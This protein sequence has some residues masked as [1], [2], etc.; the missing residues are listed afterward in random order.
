MTQKLFIIII[1]LCSVIV[2]NVLAQAS[3]TTISGVVIDEQTK[4]SLPGAT[5]YIDE[6]KQ[7]TATDH[8]GVFRI[9]DVDE[10]PYILKISFLGYSDIKDTIYPNESKTFELV[11]I[12]FNLGQVVITGTRTEKRL[13]DSPVR[14]IVINKNEIKKAG[15]VSTIEALQ[16][17]IPG[18]VS[19]PNAM[20]NNMRIRGLNSRYI[21]F[22]VDGERLV[23]EG[24]GGNVNLEQI[25][26]NDIERI[27]VVN[28]ASSSLYGSNAVGGVINI[29][30]KKPVHPIEV[31]I[32]SNFQNYNTQK[33]HFDIGTRLKKLSVRSDIFRNSSDGFD[34]PN[35]PYAARYT[36]YGTTLKGVYKFTDRVNASLNGRFFQHETFNLYNSMNVIHHLDRKLAVGSTVN[37][38]SK[39]SSNH[40]QISVNLDKFY[41]FDV[42]EKMDNKLEKGLDAYYMS[43]RFVNTYF[44]NKKLEIV[45]GAEYNQGQLSTFTSKVLGDKPATRSIT[46]INLFGQAQYTLGK[47]ISVLGTR[48]T[49]NKQFGSSVNPKLSLMYRIGKLTFRGGVGT[50]FRAPEIKELYYDFSHQGMFWVY[51]NPDLK[52]EKG[53]FSS[54]STEY[55]SNGFNTSLS[56]YYNK[57]NNKI[58]QYVII[59]SEGKEDRYYKNVSSA[60]LKGFDYN[61]GRLFLNRFMLKATYSYCDAK[62]NMT[63]LQLQSNVKHSATVSLG[64][65]GEVMKSPFSLQLSGRINSPKLYQRITTDNNGKQETLTEKSSPYNIWKVTLVKPFTIDRHTINITLK[66]DN[67]FGFKEPSF[68]NPGRQY[69]I[70][71]QYKFI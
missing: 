46:D 44:H 41:K 6:L 37:I 54:L 25:D 69:L 63:G 11:Q 59:N 51:G 50:S 34:I 58:T 23:A 13:A 67:I 17:Y 48:Y 55:T 28:E 43:A 29:I 1:L 70:G 39:D 40:Q 62:D 68:I 42:L 18:I 47:L 45:A 19:T 60:T 15:S 4:E 10:K 36:D 61:I 35:G 52:P 7:G 53:L 8:N 32:N 71:L 27:E 5:V 9:K 49:Y 3:S 21:L 66:C 65:N 57:I 56:V 14:T 22:L 64:W 26:F 20:G 33:Y 12:P 30:T 2:E 38:C 31:G 16:D 24:A